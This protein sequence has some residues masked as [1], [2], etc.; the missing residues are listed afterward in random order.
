[1]QASDLS[2]CTGVHL[3][4]LIN[5]CL[6]ARGDRVSLAFCFFLEWHC[7]AFDKC[8]ATFSVLSKLLPIA[9]KSVNSAVFAVFQQSN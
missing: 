7:T 9:N 1:M 5:V 6:V 3:L 4:V 8:C 2:A